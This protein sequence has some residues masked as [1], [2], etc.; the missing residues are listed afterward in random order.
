MSMRN[1]FFIVKGHYANGVGEC[2]TSEVTNDKVYIGG[3]NPYSEDTEEWYMLMDKKTFHCVGCGKDIHAL[4]ETLTKLLIRFKDDE[5]KYFKHVSSITSEDYYEVTFLGRNPLTPEQ[6][7]KKAIGKCPRTS[8]K[9]KELYT[10]V[11]KSYGDYLSDEIES[12]EEKAYNI[13]KNG[14]THS[15]LKR[16][17]KPKAIINSNSNTIEEEE[18]A[19]LKK[20]KGKLLFRKM[21]H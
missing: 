21:K 7:T 8:P 6:R 15:S 18:S 2:Y 3:Y 17:V 16:K 13:L 11:L 1:L 12:A 14:I 10:H 4:L 20:K 9:M 5:R 19:P